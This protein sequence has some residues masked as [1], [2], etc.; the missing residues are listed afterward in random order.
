MLR[1]SQ[2]QRFENDASLSYK[3]ILSFVQTMEVKTVEKEFDIVRSEKKSV[4]AGFFEMTLVT[5]MESPD[6]SRTTYSCSIS[7]GIGDEYVLRRKWKNVEFSFW[8]FF[9]LFVKLGRYFYNFPSN[10]GDQIGWL[11]YRT[12]SGRCTALPTH[13]KYTET[14]SLCYNT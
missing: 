5:V 1:K 12:L 13:I 7:V 8:V 4:A 11:L 2:L 6:F 14:P 9:T 3:V 10:P